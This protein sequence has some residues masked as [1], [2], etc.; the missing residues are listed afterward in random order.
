MQS[1]ACALQSQARRI[2]DKR[3]LA[4]RWL[5]RCSCRSQLREKVSALSFVLVSQEGLHPG[6]AEL[7]SQ[8]WIRSGRSMAPLKL[9]HVVLNRHLRMHASLVM[10]VLNKHVRGA[11]SSLSIDIC[12]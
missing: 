5:R 4:R 9:A 11:M 3:V 8:S 10:M 2:L 7:R 12:P 6:A 1:H